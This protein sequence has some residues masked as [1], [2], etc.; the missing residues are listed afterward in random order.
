LIPKD[1]SVRASLIDHWDLAQTDQMSLDVE[2][3]SID[4]YCTAA[5]VS[6]DFVKIGIAGMELPAFGGMPGTLR[7]RPPRAIISELS[8][9]E[10]AVGRPE[11]L[12]D[13]LREFATYLCCGESSVTS[14]TNEEPPATR[15]ST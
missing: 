9:F 14:H 10:D 13:F 2:T 11:E 15:V 12:V 6:P 7:G 8:Q 4:H 1:D 5:R 3:V